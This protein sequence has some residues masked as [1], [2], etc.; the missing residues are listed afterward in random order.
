[1]AELELD[2]LSKH[3]GQTTALSELSLRIGPGELVSLLG[4]SGCGKTT[5]LRIVA[6]FIQ[7]DT[8]VVRIDGHVV[9]G[10]PPHQRNIGIVFQNYALFPH[11]TVY[12]NVA[13]G[14]KM[15]Y[16]PAAELPRRVAR[17]I[18]LVR[19]VGLE[20][21]YPNQLS[22]GQQQRVAVAR[23]VVINPRVL[24]LDEPL[25][26]LDAKLRVSTREELR[27][28]QRELG[29]TTIFVTHDQDEAL[30]I[31]DRVAVMQSGRLE[32]VGTPEELYER[33]RTAFVA[34]FIGNSNQF[35][36]HVVDA[37]PG[38]VSIEISGTETRIRAARS[39]DGQSL[40]RGAPVV[41][42]V[43]PERITLRGV[44]YPVEGI[45]EHNGF[46][47]RVFSRTF[48][49]AVTRYRVNIDASMTLTV[50][51]PNV[52]GTRWSPGDRV[53]VGWRQENT[54]VIG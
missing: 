45:E 29:V 4:P 25:S 3:Y 7:P 9:N 32:Q 49:G 47:G 46:V 23:A 36:G 39:G 42:L 14:L 43:R 18:E 50:D 13:F 10:V 15:R 6:G 37:H 30:S 35:Q 12:G 48:V 52:D 17:A 41:V 22:G 26:N 2:R 20:H 11:M 53:R 51:L 38:G 8:G 31:S 1:M 54:V 5:A 24:L 44:D 28:L 33:P 21:R 19:L 27:Q 16:V 34:G 40:G